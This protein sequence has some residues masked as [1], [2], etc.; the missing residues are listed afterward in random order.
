MSVSPQLRLSYVYDAMLFL[1]EGDAEK[2]ARAIHDAFG[3]AD[4]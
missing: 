4:A 3:L 2:A 1:Y